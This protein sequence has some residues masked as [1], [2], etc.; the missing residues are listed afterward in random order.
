M[1]EFSISRF[2]STLGIF[3]VLGNCQSPDKIEVLKLEMMSTDGWVLM[4]MH[5][6]TTQKIINQ[7]ITELRNHPKLGSL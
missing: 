2:E 3:K 7:L 4:D 5:Q 6:A 1:M